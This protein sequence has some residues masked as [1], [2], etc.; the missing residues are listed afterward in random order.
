MRGTQLEARAV[1][2]FEAP[3]AA[4]GSFCL[5]IQ[6][7]GVKSVRVDQESAASGVCCRWEIHSGAGFAFD[8]KNEIVRDIGSE[9]QRSA[10]DWQN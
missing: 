6:L 4:K 8:V 7:A 5:R 10:F 9:H 1:E 2:S 3:F